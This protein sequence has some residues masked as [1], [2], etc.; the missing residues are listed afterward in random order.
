MKNYWLL[1]ITISFS[2]HSAMLLVYMPSLVQLKKIVDTAR[3]KKEVEIMPQLI[4]KAKSEKKINVDDAAKFPAENT[5]IPPPFIKNFIDK[6]VVEN[7]N[8]A[9]LDKPR[10][11]ENNNKEIFISDAPNMEELKKS[12]SYMGY[13][14]GIRSKLLKVAHH[15]YK[16]KQN[17]KVLL[18]FTVS[19]DGS[20]KSVEGNSENKILKELAVEVVKETFPFIAFPEGI[21]SS[22]CQFTIEIEFKYK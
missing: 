19:R 11:T 17:G 21:R 13:Y 4:K 2:A 1:A 10:L 6:F 5:G 7:K 18:N 14:D 9:S 8:I 20:L 22:F 16:I 3:P 12:P 15:K